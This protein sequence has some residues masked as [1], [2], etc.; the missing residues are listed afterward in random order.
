MLGILHIIPANPGSAPRVIR[1]ERPVTE[2]EIQ[3]AVGGP[4]G[5]IANFDTVTQDGTIS[6]C[7]AFCDEQARHRARPQNRQATTLWSQ[8]LV[9]R[10]GAGQAELP[11]V[12]LGSV[13]V[14]T[15]DSEF[16]EAL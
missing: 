4:V 1:L 11:E 9:R 13:V 16:L 14:I 8:A 2:K 10:F 7:Y 6:L 12:L 15:G 3:D 5:F